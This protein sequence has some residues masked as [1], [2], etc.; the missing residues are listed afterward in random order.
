MEINDAEVPGYD[1]LQYSTANT[2]GSSG[3][4]ISRTQSATCGT[5][6]NSYSDTRGCEARCAGLPEPFAA[7]CAR[8]SAWGWRRGDPSLEFKAVACPAGFKTLISSAF[9]RRG[10]EEDIDMSPFETPAELFI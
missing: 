7:A 1:N 5:W 10:P 3:T 6:Y 2:C 8:F 9:G 4:H